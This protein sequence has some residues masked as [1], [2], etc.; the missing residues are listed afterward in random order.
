MIFLKL[1]FK[2]TFAFRVT[3]GTLELL[4]REGQRVLTATE[5]T[6]GCREQRDHQE[7]R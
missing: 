3:E 6:R 5:E 4:D 7:S 1:N 2:K